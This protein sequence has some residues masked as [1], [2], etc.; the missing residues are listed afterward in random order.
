M[1]IS[2]RPGIDWVDS[3][4][5]RPTFGWF[6][7]W[8]SAHLRVRG[9]GGSWSWLV[10]WFSVMFEIFTLVHAEKSLL[11]L[12]DFFLI[13]PLLT[14]WWLLTHITKDIHNRKI[15]RLY[16]QSSRWQGIFPSSGS[17]L[18]VGTQMCVGN[19]CLKNICCIESRLCRIWSLSL[20]FWLI[21][22]V[23]LHRNIWKKLVFP[24]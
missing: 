5:F 3:V 14:N 6:W 17:Q 24:W 18:G 11:Q 8:I 10:G 9:R 2:L 1:Q 20:R 13:A 15:G 7:R 16:Q 21:Y 22:Y 23:T 4:H 12:Q 19:W